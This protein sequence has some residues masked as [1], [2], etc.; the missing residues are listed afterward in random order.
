MSEAL[1]WLGAVWA[2]A[3]LWAAQAVLRAW[4]EG[5]RPRARVTRWNRDGAAP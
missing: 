4:I 5:R 3:L 2:V 1:L